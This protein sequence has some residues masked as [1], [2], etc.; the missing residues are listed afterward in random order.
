MLID[1]HC[2]LNFPPL[3]E[4]IEDVL[5]RAREAGVGRIVI[6]G[7][8]AASWPAIAQLVERH[9]QL[10]AAFGLHPWRLDEAERLEELPRWLDHPRCVAVGEIGLDFAEEGHEDR[11]LQ[12]ASLLKQIDMAKERNLPILLHCRRA[13]DRLP[14]LL[15]PYAPIR[16]VLHAYSQSPQLAERLTALGLH[17]GFGGTIT[18]KHAKRAKKSVISVPL[19]RIVLET[20]AP[21]IG[22]ESTP[23]QDVEPHHIAEV[24]QALAELKGIDVEAVARATSDNVADLFGWKSAR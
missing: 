5:A 24:A 1:T 20:D 17:L 12:V 6:P 18:R 2:H 13:F 11:E 4:H 9:E 21:S 15:V 19:E 22:T 7:Y 8:D 10:Y 23:P 14:D 3:V 16:G